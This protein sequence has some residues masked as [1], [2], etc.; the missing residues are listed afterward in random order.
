MLEGGAETGSNPGRRSTNP[1]PGLATGLHVRFPPMGCVGLREEGV[2]GTPEE[3]EKHLRIQGRGL[4]QTSGERSWPR[5]ELD[6]EPE[7]AGDRGMGL[8]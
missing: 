5:R 4:L 8:G 6:T 3:E 2:P 7:E 1:S